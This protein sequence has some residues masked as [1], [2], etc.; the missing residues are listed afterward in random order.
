MKTNTNNSHNINEEEVID[1][2]VLEKKMQQAILDPDGWR[3]I[4][5]NT[6]YLENGKIIRKIKRK[7]HWLRQ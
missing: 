7:N 3:V 1:V 6:V 5:D 4:P 2:N